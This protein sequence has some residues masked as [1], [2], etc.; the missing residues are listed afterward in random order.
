LRQPPFPS[1]LYSLA[2]D[3]LVA[4]SLCAAG[5]A[6]ALLFG[7]QQRS[8]MNLVWPATL[9]A[10]MFWIAMQLVM[11]RGFATTC[12]VNWRFVRAVLKEEM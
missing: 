11:M 12:S 1:F 7:P 2:V 4:T 3:S 9:F 8:I 6:V 10:S 5:V